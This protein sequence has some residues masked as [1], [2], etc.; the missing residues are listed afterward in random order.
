MLLSNWDEAQNEIITS[1]QHVKAW[2]VPHTDQ[3]Q[4]V[5][6]NRYIYMLAWFDSR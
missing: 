6:Y 3:L 1:N 2:W 5:T 4:I